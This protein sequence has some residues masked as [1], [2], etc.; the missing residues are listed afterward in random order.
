M[1]QQENPEKTQD[2]SCK[3]KDNLKQGKNTE[4][5]TTV[6]DTDKQQDKVADDPVE[7]KNDA[8]STTI[9]KDHNEDSA[10]TK[11]ADNDKTQ[12]KEEEEVKNT[13]ASTSSL[14]TGRRQVEGRNKRMFG[15]LLKSLEPVRRKTPIAARI[16]K[17]EEKRREVE[18]RVEK[19]KAETARLLEEKSVEEYRRPFKRRYEDE[20][21]RRESFNT[22]DKYSS[23]LRDDN[24]DY[25]NENDDMIK[26]KKFENETLD[27]ER[28][29]Y[30]KNEEDEEMD[31]QRDDDDDDNNNNRQRSQSRERSNSPTLD[32]RINKRRKSSLSRDLSLEDDRNGER[33]RGR[34]EDE[35]DNRDYDD[36]DRNGS[37]YKSFS[38]RQDDR[39]YYSDE[40]EEDED[41]EVDLDGEK[42]TRPEPWQYDQPFYTTTKP[43]IAYL[44]YLLTRE[45]R[46]MSNR[47]N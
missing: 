17:Q 45:Q 1:S 2:D 34:M 16:S 18:A 20:N 10:N 22:N 9:S 8:K 33:R 42:G 13:K 40:E 19:K 32:T 6:K 47:R 43:S 36:D 41:Y 27:E 24:D 37:Y 26:D 5:V 31:E 15:H 11:K 12:Q 29:K 28:R 21:I 4:N 25:Y 44:P 14:G 35:K 7:E 38:K 3:T 39:R 46:M 23:P 30:K